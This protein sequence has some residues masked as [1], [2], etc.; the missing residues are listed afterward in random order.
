M[1]YETSATCPLHLDIPSKNSLCS[2]R[3]ISRDILSY[4][5]YT[6]SY[7]VT[8]NK[9]ETAVKNYQSVSNTNIPRTSA[10]SP[11]NKVL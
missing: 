8:C 6:G 5:F 3:K 2:F 10:C 9:Y 1:C 4:I 11:Q 7:S